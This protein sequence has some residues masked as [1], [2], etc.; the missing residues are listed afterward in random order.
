MTEDK[1]TGGALA[2]YEEFLA[3]LRKDIAANDPQYVRNVAVMQASNWFSNIYPQMLEAA[4]KVE[5]DPMP[6]WEI[7]YYLAAM[8]KSLPKFVID[9]SDV[10]LKMA[11]AL[12]HAKDAIEEN[13]ALKEARDGAKKPAD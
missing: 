7:I 2:E 8:M 12:L 3:R 13:K 6:D 1:P 9:S 11:A 5:A 10:M 4:N